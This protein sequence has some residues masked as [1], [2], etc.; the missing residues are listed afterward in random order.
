MKLGPQTHFGAKS[1]SERTIQLVPKPRKMVIIIPRRQGGTWEGVTVTDWFSEWICRMWGVLG[2]HILIIP[3]SLSLPPMRGAAV[4]RAPIILQ[5]DSFYTTISNFVQTPI[6]STTRFVYLDTFNRR[7][8][9][10]LSWP[11]GRKSE[12]TSRGSKIPGK[13]QCLYFQFLPRILGIPI[14]GFQLKICSRSNDTDLPDKES[15]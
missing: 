1:Q 14:V 7:G 9:R 11:K 2:P 13:S 15:T 8:R 4:G 12:R 10:I 3:T 5:N 6:L